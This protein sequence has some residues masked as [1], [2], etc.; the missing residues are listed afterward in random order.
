MMASMKIDVIIP[1]FNRS[2]ILSRAIESVLNQT[3]RD[4]LLHIVDDG[5]TDD[6]Q[7]LLGKYATDDR[8]R[9]YTQPNKGVSA[10]R[11]LAA[12]KGSAPWIAF[13]DSDDEWL[14]HKLEAQIKAIKASPALRFF[15]TEET[16]IRNGVRVNPKMKHQ[17]SGPDLLSRSLDFCLIS[18][19]TSL[20]KRELFLELGGF[21][22]EFIVCEDYDLWLKIL[23]REEVGFINEALTMKYGGHEDQLSQKFSA[24]DYWRIRSLS[25]LYHSSHLDAVI[26]EKIKMVILQKSIILQKGYVKHNNPEKFNEI[27]VIIDSLSPLEFKGKGQ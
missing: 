22:E 26:R 15:H 18:P 7:T 13:L 10:A 9:L 16:W 3:H 14:P 2:P 23:T 8:V 1:T 25:E 4:F 21:N 24:M 11:N 20:I 6:T 17:K 19:S 27:Q 5:S 12:F